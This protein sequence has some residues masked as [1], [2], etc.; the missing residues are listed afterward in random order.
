M[1]FLIAAFVAAAIPFASAVTT[2]TV[3]IPACGLCDANN[4]L[5]AVRATD[6]SSYLAVTITPSTTTKTI[7][8]TVSVIPS[9]T[10]TLSLTA[11]LTSGTSITTVYDTAT[12]TPV[13]TES[14]AITV[15]TSTQTLYARHIAATSALIPSY[16]SACSGY[17]SYSSACSCIGVT[18]SNRTITASI[19]TAYTTTYVSVTLLPVTT[20]STVYPFTQTILQTTEIDSIAVASLTV[21]SET[22]TLTST[23]YAV[24]T[25]TIFFCARTTVDG[26]DYLLIEGAATTDPPYL[27]PASEDIPTTDIVLRFADEGDSTDS[28]NIL[29]YYPGNID[30]N[31]YQ[32]MSY[33]LFPYEN[34]PDGIFNLHPEADYY[35]DYDVANIPCTTGGVDNEG[36]VIS[37]SYDCTALACSYDIYN[38]FAIIPG[39]ASM[40]V[41]FATIAYITANGLIPVDFTKSYSDCGGQ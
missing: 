21:A 41:Y 40:T 33:K 4:C 1:H 27:L 8:Q 32:G 37:C 19:P 23:A 12:V 35:T 28:A 18:Q 20:T 3:T 10:E 22:E 36:A 6:C 17:A 2:V 16:A 11:T 9:S 25:S 15:F 30:T 13:V 26:L 31:Y 24:A 38:T 5:G 39:D 34:T 14:A 7:T 29:I